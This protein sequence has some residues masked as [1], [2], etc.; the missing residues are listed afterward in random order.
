MLG[1]TEASITRRF[2]RP[3]TLS[4]SL[5]TLDRGTAQEQMAGPRISLRFIPATIGEHPPL[6]AS[7]RECIVQ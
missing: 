1:I 3:W 5:T 6:P 2:C 7:A 4:S